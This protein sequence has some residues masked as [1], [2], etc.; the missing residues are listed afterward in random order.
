M[1]YAMRPLKEEELTRYLEVLRKES[2]RR[3][4]YAAAAAVAIGTGARI[5]EVL[6]MR[7]KDVMDETGK[8]REKLTRK[9]EKKRG[10]VVYSERI[11]PIEVLREMVQRYLDSDERRRFFQKEDD[12]LFSARYSGKKL[13]YDHCYD[14]QRELLREAGLPVRGVAFHGL[15]KSLLTMVFYERQ[16]KT[17]DSMAALRYV[18]EIACHKSLDTTLRYVGWELIVDEG[19]TF[20]DCFKGIEE[21]LAKSRCAGIAS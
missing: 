14:I 16:K 15:R 18:Q 5:G 8:V 10:K 20:R 11:F 6:Q 7:V 2:E 21:R 12:Y 13:T 9:L 17:G 1:G 3:P 19:Q 4:V